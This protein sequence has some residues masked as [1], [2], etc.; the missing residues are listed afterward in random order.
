MHF[1][2]TSAHGF[3]ECEKRSFRPAMAFDQHGHGKKDGRGGN[4][5]LD[6]DR[7]IASDVEAPFQ[8][9]A[10]IAEI[11]EAGRSS[12]SIIDDFLE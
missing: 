12:L 5:Q 2:G 11:G 9:S 8:C 10:R 4:G 7:G 3:I 1:L 6:P